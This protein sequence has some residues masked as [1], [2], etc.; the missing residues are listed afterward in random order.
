MCPKLPTL[1]W[2]LY[3]SQNHE[4]GHWQQ[5]SNGSGKAKARQKSSRRQLRLP[6]CVGEGSVTSHPTYTSGHTGIPVKKA[7]THFP[8]A[9]AWCV[10]TSSCRWHCFRPQLEMALKVCYRN[11]PSGQNIQWILACSLCLE[12]EM[13]EVGISPNL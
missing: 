4:I 2:M 5:C 9:P 7:Q 12:G 8:H 13:A 3:E 10:A 11:L 6:W 1:N